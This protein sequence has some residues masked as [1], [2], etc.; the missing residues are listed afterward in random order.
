MDENL[1]ASVTYLAQSHLGD[2]DPGVKVIMPIYPPQVRSKGPHVD[3]Y[4]LGSVGIQ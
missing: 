3:T 4:T 1:V 2:Q